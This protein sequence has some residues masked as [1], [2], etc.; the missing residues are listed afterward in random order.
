[1]RRLLVP[2]LLLAALAVPAAASARAPSVV[3]LPVDDT[4]VFAGADSPCAFDTTFTSSGTV[5]S[6]T[7]FDNG[8]NPV[9]QT[10]HGSL[11]HTFFS[12]WH[13][14]VSK[15]PAPGHIDPAAGQMVDTAMED[16]FHL[17][18][19]GVILGPAGR[20]TFAADRSPLPLVGIAG[21][22]PA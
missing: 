13:T 7:F 16:S 14:R 1:M 9:R 18:A 20:L 6:T 8:G 4:F 2:L 15:G 21:P 19:H 11:T 17:P 22:D 3:T 12:A 10:I 5:K